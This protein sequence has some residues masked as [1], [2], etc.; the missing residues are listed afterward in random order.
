MN[1]CR[2]LTISAMII[3]S[4]LAYADQQPKLQLPAPAF[5]PEMQDSRVLP[6]T[7]LSSGLTRPGLTEVPGFRSA[8]GERRLGTQGP[9]DNSWNFD[10]PEGYTDPLEGRRG[11]RPRS[12]VVSPG[13]WS[14]DSL[15]RQNSNGGTDSIPFEDGGKMVIHTN[16]DGSQYRETYDSTGSLETISTVERG[17]D[18]NT[19]TTLTREPGG[20]T[21]VRQEH[22][23]RDG[24]PVYD[25]YSVR[26]GNRYQP[27]DSSGGGSNGWHNPITGQSSAGYGLRLGGNQVRPGP[28]QS[29][30]AATP[31]V[32]PSGHELVTNPHP[33]V[34]QGP[35]AP[36]QIDRNAG[37]LVNPPR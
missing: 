16:P 35:T 8:P 2:N 25:S 6:Q 23:D 4:P 29:S 32:V 26:P 37:K 30:S 5:A 13:S 7:D 24:N 15:T 12:T 3:L 33:E 20:A 19:I 27:D 31:S 36:R 22:Y 9:G 18:G 14:Q 1:L 17:A 34:Y 10:T 28:E 11:S 21:G